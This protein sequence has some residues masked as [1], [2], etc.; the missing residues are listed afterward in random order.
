MSFRELNW[1]EISLSVSLP[2][3]WVRDLPALNVRILNVDFGITSRSMPLFFVPEGIDDASKKSRLRSIRHHV[4]ADYRERRTTADNK[5]QQQFSQTRR[6]A[7]TQEARANSALPY[8]SFIPLQK[9]GENRSLLQRRKGNVTEAHPAAFAAKLPYIAP[10]PQ[11]PISYGNSDPFDTSVIPIDPIVSEIMKFFFEVYTP[12]HYSMTAIPGYHVER[13][14]YFENAVLFSDKCSTYAILTCT[15]QSMQPE[16][17]IS[18]YLKLPALQYYCQS[19][20][21]LKTRLANGQDFSSLSTQIAVYSLLSAAICRGALEEAHVHAKSLA[22]LVQTD[23]SASNESFC[24]YTISLD[25]QRSAMT[26]TRPCFDYDIWLP[27]RF[28]TYWA[29][30][31]DLVPP[32]F[33]PPELEKTLDKSIHNPVLRDVFAA[34]RYLY[35]VF[36]MCLTKAEFQ[37]MKTYT[38]LKSYVNYLMGRMINHYLDCVEDSDVLKSFTHLYEDLTLGAYFS[39]PAERSYHMPLPIQAITALSVLLWTRIVGGVEASDVG[40][41]RGMFTATTTIISHLKRYWLQSELLFLSDQS[42]RYSN[43]QV[44][45][46][47]VG[48]QLEWTMASKQRKENSSSRSVGDSSGGG[49]VDAGSTHAQSSDP[50]SEH[51][52]AAHG[53]FNRRLAALCRERGLYT[54]V[55]VQAVLQ[56]FVYTDIWAP[57]GSTW[58]HLTIGAPEYMWR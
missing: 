22:H 51:G 3:R 26:V 50:S 14:D 31:A 1:Y 12:A 52:E 7:A 46:L 41:R 36:G 38:F 39:D 20:A 23:V 49:G 54:W 57:H 11:S 2:Y 48:A 13:V 35:T 17:L 10:N 25:Q 19:V 47:Y 27:S 55:S 9:A 4:L 16:A 58:F 21:G 42:R 40:S 15:I 5:R 34:L 24:I 32:Q 28:G 29:E 6:L 45:T 44:W 56:G 37:N 30:I 8:S 43:L 33:R 18:S 53:F